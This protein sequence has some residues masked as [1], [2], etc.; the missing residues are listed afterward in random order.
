MARVKK[1]ER[2]ASYT[3][4]ST[5]IPM[6]P[7]SFN[8]SLV[9]LPKLSLIRRTFYNAFKEFMTTYV[10]LCLRYSIKRNNKSFVTI[11]LTKY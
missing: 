7:K 1:L 2:V 4:K 11:C 10:L 3:G 6:R 5:N 9:P 8:K